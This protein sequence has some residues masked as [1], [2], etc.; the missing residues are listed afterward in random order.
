MHTALGKLYEVK[1]LAL[2]RPCD[3]RRQEGVHECLE[4]RSPPLR[5]GI[6]NLPFVIYAFAGEL[7]SNRC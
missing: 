7:V 3:M 1:F 2:F 6:T 4:V 5:E